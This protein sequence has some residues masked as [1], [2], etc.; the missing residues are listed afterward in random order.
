MASVSAA[1]ALSTRAFSR[2][3]VKES[4]LFVCDLQ[5]KF[6]CDHSYLWITCT[7]HKI[8]KNYDSTSCQVEKNN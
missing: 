6:R 8:E 5:E 1:V 3:S 2:V 7:Y 4:A